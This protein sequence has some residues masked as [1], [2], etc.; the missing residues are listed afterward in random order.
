MQGGE[1]EKCGSCMQPAAV[2]LTCKTALEVFSQ[3]QTL[4]LQ[5]EVAELR[6]RLARYEPVEKV[7][8][9]KSEEEFRKMLSAVYSIFIDWVKTHV[10]EGDARKADEIYTKVELYNVVKDMV[11]VWTG[12]EELGDHVAWLCCESTEK[13]M[14][15]RANYEAEEEMKIVR[16]RKYIF[17]DVIDF[18]NAYLYRINAS[19][20]SLAML[21]ARPASWLVDLS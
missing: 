18:L 3:N 10:R 12:K 7:E 2:G 6:A 19:N 13:L 9:F 20:F 21:G 11:A 17:H 5:K 15:L 4:A 14:D 1:G 8:R 16:L